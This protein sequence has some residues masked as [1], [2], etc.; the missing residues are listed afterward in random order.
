MIFDYAENKG[1]FLTK[2]VKRRDFNDGVKQIEFDFANNVPLEEVVGLSEKLLDNA[3]R[4]IATK[5]AKR[6]SARL[7]HWRIFVPQTWNIKQ[8]LRASEQI[9]RF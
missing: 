5:V 8:A 3:A 6:L 1:K 7:I 4:A 9:R 2:T